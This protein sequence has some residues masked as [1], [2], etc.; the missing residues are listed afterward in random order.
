MTLQGNDLAMVLEAT[1]LRAGLSQENMAKMCG[2]S[3]SMIALVEKG[4]REP[5]FK[6]CRIWGKA[7]GQMALIKLVGGASIGEDEDDDLHGLV[8]IIG[9]S[10]RMR[11]ATQ[12]MQGA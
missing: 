6:I 4:E 7:T 8:E 2:C 1:R 12:I 3:Q 11:V 9:E 5:S 10:V